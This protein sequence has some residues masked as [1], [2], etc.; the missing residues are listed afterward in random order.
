MGRSCND[1]YHPSYTGIY[2]WDRENY[3]FPKVTKVGSIFGHRIDYQ[4]NGVGVLRGQQQQKIY[5][6]PPPPSH[7]HLPWVQLLQ[8]VSL[9]P[10]GFACNHIAFNLII[11][12]DYF[13]EVHVERT[14]HFY[15][16]SSPP[17][18]W[19]SVHGR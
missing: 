9:L 17:P 18:L 15:S 1:L 3:I 6:P 7:H 13:S 11:V 14:F 2:S 10:V 5:P 4:Y 12:Y 16:Y 8:Q 19:M